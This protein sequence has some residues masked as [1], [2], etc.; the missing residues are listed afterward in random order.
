MF[1]SFYTPFEVYILYITIYFISQNMNMK[2]RVPRSI[3]IVIELYT[4]PIVSRVTHLTSARSI[5]IVILIHKGAIISMVISFVQKNKIFKQRARCAF[6]FCNK[7]L[8]IQVHSL[9]SNSHFFLCVVE[10]IHK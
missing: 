7:K 8:K 4:P 5:I 1:Y 2:Q 10:S 6:L 9:K 3:C